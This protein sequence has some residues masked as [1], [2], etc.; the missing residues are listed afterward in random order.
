MN[1]VGAGQGANRD[2][3][4]QAELSG[5]GPNAEGLLAGTYSHCTFTNYVLKQADLKGKVFEECCFRDCDLSLAEITRTSFRKVRFERCKLLGLRFDQCH[6]FL[7]E[8]DF[9]ACLMDL[10]SFHACG[11]KRTKFKDCRLRETDL[12][13][14]DLREVCFSGSDLGGAIFDRTVLEGADLRT[15]RH[16]TIDPA[17]NRIRGARFSRDGL[18]GLLGNTGILIE[19]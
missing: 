6:T 3:I 9:S 15:A 10:A 19:D 7:L 13:A 18:E 1:N 5:T 2:L 14:A 17:N 4:E 16:Y 8:L 12:S 11:L